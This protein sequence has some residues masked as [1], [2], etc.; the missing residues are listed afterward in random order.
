[1][2]GNQVDRVQA[3]NPN[4]T[5]DD[6][7]GEIQSAENFNGADAS[8]IV[9]RSP[10]YVVQPQTPGVPI[11]AGNDGA[12][13]NIQAAVV[14]DVEITREANLAHVELATAQ[15]NGIK[16]TAAQGINV[17]MEE[18]VRQRHEI[19]Q[20]DEGLHYRRV[21]SIERRL[22]AEIVGAICIEANLENPQQ[23]SIEESGDPAVDATCREKCIDACCQ[24]CVCNFQ[25]PFSRQ[26][27]KPLMEKR[28][29]LTPILRRGRAK[30]WNI[31]SKFAFPLVRDSIR[32]FWVTAE[33]LTVLAAFTLSLTSFIKGK[34]EIFNS[35]HL[36]L[37]ILST[38]LAVIDAVFALK[39]CKSCKACKNS[40]QGMNGD[41][42]SKDT[43]EEN[44]NCCQKCTTGCKTISDFF[45]ILLAEV[46][47]YP[48]LVCDL[49]EVIT[50][51]V[52]NGDTAEDRVSFALFILSSLALILY[53]YIARVFIL[54][55]MIINVHKQR[56]PIVKEADV[57][58]RHKYD[59]SIAIGALWFQ[60]FFLIHTLGQMVAQ[61]MMLVAIG[62][63][64][65]HANKVT[66]F[67]C[68]SQE[69]VCVSPTLWYMLAAGWILPICGFLTFFIVTYYW[70]QQ[71]PIGLCIDFVRIM[72]MPGVDDL[73][74][75]EEHFK[76]GERSEKKAQK[77]AARLVANFVRI[78]KL[79]NDF[80]DMRK[81]GT[82]K[83]F[84]Y[85]FESPVLIILCLVYALLQLGFIVCAA[86]ADTGPS[87][88]LN[89]G[90]WINFYIAAVIM[91]IIA[92]LYTFAVAGLWIA[93][94]VG[95]LVAIA[96]LI[97]CLLL[98]CFFAMLGA[99]SDS[100]NNRNR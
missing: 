89:G 88:V 1:M 35:V 59:R 94:I 26:K 7:E 71:F 6:G 77:L 49:F 76:D 93:I 33:L 58:K 66:N 14:A 20:T 23:L 16:V 4:F 51:D 2:S 62:A 44:E 83:K 91:G 5:H 42:A 8:A 45:R 25:N 61:I 96:A 28:D 65:E 97:A 30:G 67:D 72:E 39:E 63:K 70:V 48:L 12:P 11:V 37:T 64:I 29:I 52:Y 69:S 22:Y 80:N 53:V 73:L 18:K 13:T 100:N 87:E 92:N 55:A 17:K 98:C 21:T 82:S 54:I 24:S 27:E 50:G 74:Y 3:I 15:G 84:F 68:T 90:G 60:G 95:I 46:I 99:S 34:R 40:I 56:Q 43:P 85:P 36:S 9:P 31:F 10:M 79:E 41:A 47:L 81:K 78:N 75:P 86:L 38:I 19:V 32:D 57:C